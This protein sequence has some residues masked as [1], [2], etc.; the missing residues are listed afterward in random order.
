MAKDHGPLLHFTGLSLTEARSEA[1]AA[2]GA[3]TRRRGGRVYSQA[4]RVGAP[5]VSTL[6]APAHMRDALNFAPMRDG[7][8]QLGGADL[9]AELALLI[10]ALNTRRAS[11][12]TLK[13][14]V[15]PNALRVDLR[16]PMRFP[17]GRAP[18]DDVADIML[19]YI[20]GKQENADGVARNDRPFRPVFPYFAPPHQS[21]PRSR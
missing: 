19:A 13:R 6:L 10:D 16:Q 11:K 7:A 3:P 14:L 1:Q 2:L 17:N 18:A 12:A 21:V 20:L 15:T 9:S 5:G 4:D 8:D